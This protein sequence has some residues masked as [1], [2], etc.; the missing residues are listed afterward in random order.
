MCVVWIMG[1]HH[2]YCVLLKLIFSYSLYG[3]KL[4]KIWGQ[5]LGITLCSIWSRNVCF[6][7]IADLFVLWPITASINMLYCVWYVL[8]KGL[9]KWFMVQHISTNVF[10]PMD[11][12]AKQESSICW[13]TFKSVSCTLAV[14]WNV[15]S[16]HWLS[17]LKLLICGLKIKYYGKCGESMTTR[18]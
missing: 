15:F 3:T 5:R 6:D 7:T 2:S 8:I 13:C 4:C 16:L 18:F 9:W 17:S 10:D 1:T 12:N 11:S 14:R